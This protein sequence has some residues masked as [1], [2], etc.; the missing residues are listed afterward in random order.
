ME[1]SLRT[2]FVCAFFLVSGA[3]LAAAAGLDAA[4]CEVVWKMVDVDKKGSIDAEEAK[5]HVSDFSQVDLDKNGAINYH[6]FKE[7]C[8]AGLVTK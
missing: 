1:T 5:S 7:G 4:D 6:E 3:S 8:K 2:L